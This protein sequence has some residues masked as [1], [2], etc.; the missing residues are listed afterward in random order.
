M[1]NSYPNY[2]GSAYDP[3]GVLNLDSRLRNRTSFR[4]PVCLR[5]LE[6][7]LACS[8]PASPAESIE[9]AAIGAIAERYERWM[10]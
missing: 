2:L 9:R 1:R 8:L 7:S 10:K 3:D 6:R 4:R 5:R